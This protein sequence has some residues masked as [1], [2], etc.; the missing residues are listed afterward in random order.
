MFANFINLSKHPDN[1]VGSSTIIIKDNER[2]IESI[3]G[4]LLVHNPFED[5]MILGDESKKLT[6]FIPPECEAF[7]ILPLN[8]LF[9]AAAVA[10]PKL[11]FFDVLSSAESYSAHI[12]AA[13]YKETREGYSQELLQNID[14]QKDKIVNEE[15]LLKLIIFEK[16][17]QAKEMATR[18]KRQLAQD[19][20]N[21]IDVRALIGTIERKSLINAGN[22]TSLR[23]S[24]LG[25]APGPESQNEATLNPEEEVLED[26][27]VAP[28]RNKDK[29]F[30]AKQTSIPAVKEVEKQSPQYGDIASGKST[31]EDEDRNP[32]LLYRTTGSKGK[33]PPGGSSPVASS[34][35]SDIVSNRSPDSSPKGSLRKKDTTSASLSG[36]RSSPQNGSPKGSVSNKRGGTLSSSASSPNLAPTGTSLSVKSTKPSGR[37]S[38]PKRGI[39]PQGRVSPLGSLK[40]KIS[41]SPGQKDSVRR[42]SFSKDQPASP[43]ASVR[44]RD[45]GRRKPQNYDSISSASSLWM[46]EEDQARFLQGEGDDFPPQRRPRSTSVSK[47]VAAYEKNMHLSL[48]SASGI[49]PYDPDD[50]NV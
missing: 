46:S 48:R 26:V 11:P 20:V 39:S 29:R 18:A 15:V 27:P 22:V 3:H 12:T 33:S 4:H 28:P 8:D 23:E 2:K 40:G 14:A 1:C 5:N 7:K 34:K 10:L 24:L 6:N 37:S 44:S 41:S 43:P 31:R 32:R 47:R 36:K 45:N 35:R 30:G 50:F 17:V 38:S 16:E 19:V 49:N 21:F 25:V 13:M 42:H 9:K